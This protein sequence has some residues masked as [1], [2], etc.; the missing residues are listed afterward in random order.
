MLD[1]YARLESGEL[2]S[3]TRTLNAIEP[4]LFSWYLGEKGG[5]IQEALKCLAERVI[6]YSAEIVD[7]TPTTARDVLK[8]LYQ[9]LLPGSIRHRLGEYYTPDWL[10]QRVMNQV[11]GSQATLDPS[12]RILDP[13]CGSGTFLAEAIS[14]MVKTAGNKSPKRILQQIVE[15]V[16]GFDLSP[17]AVQAAKVN[18]LLSLAPLLRYATEPIS[19][20]VFLADSVAPPRRG[21][22]LDG[23]VFLFDSSEGEWRIPSSLA[24][25]QY[26]P[27][28]GEIF[29]EALEQERDSHWVRQQLAARVPII[30]DLDQ[31]IVDDVQKLFD[32]ILDLHQ[33]GRDGLWWQLITN[34]FAPALQE[35]FDYVVG[36]PPWV[37]WETL[38]EAYRQQNDE[39]WLSYGLR[40]DTP[41]ARRQTSVNVQMDIAMLFVAVCI[42]RY[43]RPGGR[44]GF[45]I[46]SS[47]FRSELAGRGFRKRLLPSGES[48]QFVYIDDLSKLRVFDGP[49]NQTSVLVASKQRDNGAPILV[50]E[51]SGIGANTTP[52]D[53]ELGEI[54]KRTMRRNFYAEP[55]DP[56]DPASPLLMMPRIGLRA[57]RPLRRQSPYL[58]GIRE[59]VN[60]R[61]ANGVF[62]LEILDDYGET[63][64]VQNLPSAGRNKRIS[65]VQGVIE[66]DATR[67]L[68]RGADVSAGTA[69]P[70]GAL[71]FFH[72]EQNTS[73]PLNPRKA[74][75]DFPEAYAFA[76]T[77]ETEL[78]ARRKFRSFDPSGNDWLGI[79][80][81]TTAA[82]A[83][84]K[85]VVREIAAGMV[86]APV[87]G[88]DIMPDHKLYIIPCDTALEAD[89][90]SEVLN[91]RVV[92]YVL[93]SFSNSTSITGSF[94]RYIGIRDLSTVDYSLGGDEFLAEALGL[95]LDQY[96]ALDSVAS[97]ELP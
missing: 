4:G 88:A 72:N 70:S 35:P 59:G 15:N 93:R 41:P 17:L 10:A 90:L 43:L 66:K 95:T 3:I 82:F 52:T 18:Y 48:Y 14:R 71:L 97:A 24:A 60:T 79:Y 75:Q 68:L 23:D 94:L 67:M 12:K 77:F 34:A 89:R 8:D 6:E 2:T 46:T 50:S 1:G 54:A 65:Q 78:R 21:S 57:S 80:S 19:L 74:Q 38:P 64:R 81:V 61:G 83:P 53:A 31:Q 51:W 69:T 11:T 7:I 84:H 87:H 62:F 63:I 16:V 36:N 22:L 33:A 96:Q 76:Q 42:D 30:E 91:C 32:K 45:V 25:A 92:D 49:K 28:L 27:V 29:G 39:L 86:A 40:P 13:A 20:P 85:V 47:V 73:R 9:Q 56:N 5:R 58:E 26:L 55:A 44:L 37:S